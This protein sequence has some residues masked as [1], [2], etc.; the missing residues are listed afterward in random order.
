M[1]DNSASPFSLRDICSRLY[2]VVDR[3]KLYQ[4]GDSLA[5]CVVGGGPALP[6]VEVTLDLRLNPQH[7]KV[8]QI[9]SRTG[10]VAPP[11]KPLFLG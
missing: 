2:D 10:P 11:R 7:D 8:L 6:F 4:D 9:P 3:G 5:E 1:I